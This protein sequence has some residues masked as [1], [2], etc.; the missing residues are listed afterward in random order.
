MF[1]PIASILSNQIA[2]C[3]VI[4]RE[5]YLNAHRSHD[6]EFKAMVNGMKFRD[7]KLGENSVVERGDVVKVQFTGK[8]LGGREIESTMHLS[9]SSMQVTAGGDGVV[10]AVSEGIIGMQEY[11]SRELLVPPQMHYP[12]RFPDK[13]MVYDV[14]VR[15]IVHKGDGNSMYVRKIH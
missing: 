10:K 6:V 7:T 11:G 13:I 4:K 12:D 3:D 5:T 1:R 2:L 15:A 9:G 8:L 14:M